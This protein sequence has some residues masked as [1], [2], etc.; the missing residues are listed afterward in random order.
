MPA[1]LSDRVGGSVWHG[2]SWTSATSTGKRL[3]RSSH[4]RSKLRRFDYEVS[5]S[6][7]MSNSNGKVSQ[8][9]VARVYARAQEVDD[10]GSRAGR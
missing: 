1:R 4:L 6:F 5:A 7:P 9:D 8:S 2:T 3:P 10:G